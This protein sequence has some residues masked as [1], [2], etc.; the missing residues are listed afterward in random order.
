M[1]LGNGIYIDAKYCKNVLARYINDCRCT[2]GYNVMFVKQPEQ[3]KASVI[4]LRDI[5]AHEELYVNY[6]SLY[7]LAYNLLHPGTPI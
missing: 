4:A 1:N 6:G 7:W 5:H 3:E 2:R